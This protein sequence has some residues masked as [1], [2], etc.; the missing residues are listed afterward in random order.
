MN[1]KGEENVDI[2]LRPWE[3]GDAASIVP[4]ADDWLVARNLRDA[5]PHPY[6]LADGESFVRSCVEREGKGQLCRAIVVDGEAV[7]GIGL[8]LGNDV[9]RKSAE[10]GYW[11]GRP[12][13]RRGIMT[14]AVRAMCREGFAAWDIARIYAEPYAGNAASR[15]VLEKAGFTLEG[16]LRRSVC[17]KGEILDSCIYAL[18]REEAEA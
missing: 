16:T 1:F 15:G 10:L 17:K 14:S 4:Y 18:L 8:F 2:L 11:L 3:A 13:W 6:T 9:Y 12:F 7:G 5:F